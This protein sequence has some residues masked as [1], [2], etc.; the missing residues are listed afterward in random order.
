MAANLFRR[1]ALLVSAVLLVHISATS[2]AAQS[3]VDQIVYAQGQANA[4]DI[5]IMNSDGTN[6]RKL[7]KTGDNIEPNWSPDR[8]RI[9]FSAKRDMVA[10]VTDIYIVNA[11]GA[12]EVQITRDNGTANG[13]PSWSPDGQYIAFVSNK[14]GKSDIYLTS[15]TGGS[16]T[17]LTQDKTAVFEN[18]VWSPDGGL[19]TFTSD[20][21]TSETQT[22]QIWTMDNNGANPRSL[23]ATLNGLTDAENTSPA[24]SPDGRKIA[25]VSVREGSSTLFTIDVNGKNQSL[26]AEPA[27][28]LFYENLAW[29]PDGKSLIFAAHASGKP[30]TLQIVSIASGGAK[31]Y[32]KDGI[33]MGWPAWASH[34]PIGKLKIDFSES[35]RTSSGPRQVPPVNC[36]GAPPTQLMVGMR[37]TVLRFD[38]GAA[39]VP[40]RVRAAA[41]TGANQIGEL[42]TG[43]T[44]TVVDGPKCIDR[45]I[46]W[47]IDS[48]TGVTGWAAEGTQTNYF[49]DP[50]DE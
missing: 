40:V 37:G 20:K 36:P 21:G 38:S 24:W 28:N 8:R 25:F 7:T 23:T 10:N 42:R 35:G 32:T 4:H 50:L 44:F 49:L 46:W 3:T 17:Q 14:S 19:I 1:L 29:S 12:G 45:L 16:I 6:A 2:A 11:D 39:A 5:Y 22:R 31:Q 18:P 48:D 9:A 34:K 30:Y 47:K 15:A 41:G 26:V 33:D 13:T 43:E 27:E